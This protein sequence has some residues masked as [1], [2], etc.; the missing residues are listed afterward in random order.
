MATLAKQYQQSTFAG[1]FVEVGV[2]MPIP[3]KSVSAA[4]SRSARQVV[5][6]TPSPHEAR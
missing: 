5:S 4:C 6:S 2:D 1:H 3:A